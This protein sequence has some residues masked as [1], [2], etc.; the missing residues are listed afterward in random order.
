MVYCGTYSRTLDEKGRI[1]LPR[2]FREVSVDAADTGSLYIAPGQDRSLAI[3]PLSVL[4][5]M[6]K[7][8]EES[9][10]KKPEPRAFWRMFYARVQAVELDSQGRIRVP[11][12]MGE[13]AELK[14][15]VVLIG[16]R[17]HIEI[18][19]YLRWRGYL[20]RWTTDF[21]RISE[22]AF[23]QTPFGSM[24]Q[25]DLG[26]SKEGSPGREEPE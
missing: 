20:E 2:P 15:E 19:S 24:E 25:G 11:T 14:N 10:A 12:E 7:L 9:S 17:D 21:D 6:G 5:K 13:Y 4:E 26:E 3:Y 16:V 8:L 1:S 22:S 18:W 23:S